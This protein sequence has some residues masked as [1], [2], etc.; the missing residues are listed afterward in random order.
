MHRFSAS[1]Q[2]MEDS[3]VERAVAA[4]FRSTLLQLAYRGRRVR[5]GHPACVPMAQDA[6]VH[7]V[8]KI[9]HRRRRK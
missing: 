3:F 6:Q 5:R 4:S 2:P 1:V 9:R 8:L 7:R